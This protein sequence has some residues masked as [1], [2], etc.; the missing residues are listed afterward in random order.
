MCCFFLCP[1]GKSCD[2]FQHKWCQHVIETGACCRRRGAS[3][4]CTNR[5]ITNVLRVAPQ[6]NYTVNPG[7][8]KWNI[9]RKAA[10]FHNLTCKISQQSWLSA[11]DKITVFCSFSV[12]PVFF[13]CLWNVSQT[14]WHIPIFKYWSDRETWTTFQGSAAFLKFSECS[15]KLGEI[16]L[17]E[18]TFPSI[19]SFLFPYLAIPDCTRCF[20]YCNTVKRLPLL[21]FFPL[22][23]VL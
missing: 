1:K 14:N 20:L 21:L 11:L 22:V 17:L 23:D 3:W 19:S 13:V 6:W 10:R 18:H 16:G 2:F 8:P 5:L 15:Q 7:L 12:E 9:Y 4:S